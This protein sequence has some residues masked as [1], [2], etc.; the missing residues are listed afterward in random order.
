MKTLLTIALLAI[1][2]SFSSCAVINS[3]LGLDECGY[4]DCDRQCV[5]NCNYCMIHCDT[6]NVPSDLNAKV[7]K[8]L[9]KQLEPYKYKQKK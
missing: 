4:P 7:G 3:L 6:Y 9:D 2:I 8:S 1:S 5:E